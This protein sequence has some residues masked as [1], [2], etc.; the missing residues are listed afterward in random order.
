METKAVAKAVCIYMQPDFDE[1]GTAHW[2][3]SIFEIIAATWSR[4]P[5]KVYLGTVFPLY[6]LTSHRS[7]HSLQFVPRSVGGAHA[8][9]R[10]LD[11]P[12]ED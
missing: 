2:C 3:N 6:F 4:E 10:L 7:S 9:Q 8:L 11:P 5:I 12:S 1:Q